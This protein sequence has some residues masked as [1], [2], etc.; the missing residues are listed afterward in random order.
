MVEAELDW[1]SPEN[2]LLLNP[3]WPEKDRNSFKDLILRIPAQTSTL[4]V[5]TSGSSA[6]S[7]AEVKLVALKKVA[8]LESAQ[9]VNNHLRVTDQ[10]VWGQVLP[11][12]HVGGLGIVARAYL[13]GA[14][15]FS[16]LPENK[17]WSGDYYYDCLSR[18]NI[19]LSSLVPTQIYD[20]VKDRKTPPRSLRG[21]VVGGAA[22][23]P[24]LYFEARKLGWPLLPSYGLTEACS[25]VATASLESLK[26]SEFPR[27][28]LLPHIETKVTAEQRLVIRGKSLF[29]GYAYW[30]S[31]NPVFKDPKVDGWFFTQDFCELINKT[32]KPI[33][34][35][36]EVFK[37][38]GENVSL[39]RVR[40]IVK[41]LLLK[42]EFS[43]LNILQFEIVHFE[44]PRLGT[45]LKWVVEENVDADLF[46]QF[47][48][49]VSHS[50]LPFERP[51]EVLRITKIP[52]SSIGKPLV[53]QIRNHKFK[54]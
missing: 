12:F 52:R 40:E 30:D 19:T 47:S 53:E 3:E 32:L 22:L 10:D 13:G 51:R 1:S 5:A 6:K 34:R 43:A 37:I 28:Q 36:D 24:E 23:S 35:K 33:G 50:L 48:E 2:V 39:P 45:V 14:Q 54:A 11:H 4:W 29:S 41:N 49:E 20:L 16:C 42:P 25:Q 8:F 26:K 38:G 44:D 27:L 15:I 21:I 7:F 17:K 18:F 9:A 31:E 46:T